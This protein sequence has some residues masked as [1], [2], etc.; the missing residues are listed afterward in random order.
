MG[1]WFGGGGDVNDGV[2][3]SIGNCVLAGCTAGPVRG[4]RG[5]AIDTTKKQRTAMALPRMRH[6]WLGFLMHMTFLEQDSNH[7]MKSI[8]FGKKFRDQTNG[9]Q[10][11]KNAITPS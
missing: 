7:Y 4:S 1:W 11:L 8:F 9:S 3:A 10:P 5:P 2:L 6:F